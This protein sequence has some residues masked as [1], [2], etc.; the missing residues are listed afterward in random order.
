MLSACAKINRSVAHEYYGI[1]YAYCACVNIGA[2]AYPCF[3]LVVA[4]AICFADPNKDPEVVA[5][6]NDRI[7]VFVFAFDKVAESQVPDQV[8]IIVHDS[9]TYMPCFNVTLNM[10]PFLSSGISMWSLREYNTG[11]DCHA[12]LAKTG[13]G[14][15]DP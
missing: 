13:V 9:T 12:S 8:D 10:F 11:L 2:L 7:H 15:A 4:K 6:A 14:C 3:V 1:L 5:A